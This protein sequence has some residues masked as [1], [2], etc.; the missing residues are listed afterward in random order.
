MSDLFNDEFGNN[1]DDFLNSIFDGSE[2]GNGQGQEMFG[3]SQ[4]PQ[5][6]HLQQTQTFNDGLNPQMFMRQSPPPNQMGQMSQN[7]QMTQLQGQIQPHMPHLGPNKQEQLMKMRQQIM[8]QQQQQQQ[9]Q[10]QPS[11]IQ[12]QPSQIPNHQLQPQVGLQTETLQFQS[13]Q[14]QKPGVRNGSYDNSGFVGS[15]DYQFKPNQNF[16][17]QSQPPQHLQQQPIQQLQQQQIQQQQIQQQLQAQK[18]ANPQPSFK[19]T[20]QQIA[21]LQMEV[22]SRSYLDFVRSRGSRVDV[23]NLTINN[24]RINVFFFYVLSQKLGGQLALMKAI[25]QSGS[26]RA[27]P[28]LV[29]GQKLGVINDNQ[30]QA[31][32]MQLEKEVASFYLQFIHPYEEYSLTPDG[33]KALQQKKILIQKQFI[34]NLQQ[35]QPQQFQTQAPGSLAGH[36]SPMVLQHNSPMA[37]SPQLRASE[38]FQGKA[39]SSSSLGSPVLQSSYPQTKPSRS[40]SGPQSNSPRVKQEGEPTIVKNLLANR[41]PTESYGGVDIKTV[42]SIGGEIDISKPVYLFAPELGTVDIQSLTMLL[43]NNIKPWNGEIISALNTLLV[44]SSEQNTVIDFQQCVE[45]LEALSDT[46]LK[47]LDEIA[48]DEK[49]LDT[50]EVIDYDNLR[51]NYVVDEVFNKYVKPGIK[52]EDIMFNVDSLT[53]E[54]VKEEDDDIDMDDIFSPPQEIDTRTSD[55]DIDDDEYQKEDNDEEVIEKFGFKDYNQILIDFKSENKH[56]FSTLQT[57]SAKDHSLLMVDEL[58]SITM[59]LRNMSFHPHNKTKMSSNDTFKDFLFAVIKMVGMYPEKFLFNRKRLC[60]TK[61]CLFLLYNISQEVE[62][63]SLEEAF[64]SL[65]LITSFGP[66]LNGTESIPIA[67]VDKY[68]YLPYGI[69]ALTKLLVREPHNRSFMKAVLTG[70]LNVTSNRTT[71]KIEDSDKRITR[72][73]ITKYLHTDDIHQGQ[74]LTRTFYLFLCIVPFNTNS[75]EFSKI[76]NLRVSTFTQTFFGAKILVDLISDAESEFKEL[77]TRWLIN[78]RS[79]ILVNLLKISISLNPESAKNK[80]LALV[81]LKCMIMIN[82]L[83]NNTVMVL[84]NGASDDLRREIKL[85]VSVRWLYPDREITLETLMNPVSEPNLCNELLRLWGL[86]KQIEVVV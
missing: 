41:K 50:G 51:T 42:S 59:I 47:V 86:L 14:S 45:L 67:N 2:Q 25:H 71:I 26:N 18:P 1:G 30:N 31:S 11:Q 69:D 60:L 3:V 12:Q 29:I 9:I 16:Q 65:A 84:E 49:E 81:L 17:R 76:V 37:N 72:K 58:I 62:L 52:D 32:K 15:T 35:E 10:Q 43:K 68:S 5:S 7:P 78:N 38:A 70:D 48:Y 56:H 34:L 36:Q 83:V 82:T 23:N 44:T 75:F 46:G 74:L 64:L 40:A 79:E 28:W 22:F 63:R 19:P 8:Q 33:Q 21:Q 85:L 4:H 77:S 66:D 55:D 73:L 6:T 61:D 27:S 53:G 24:K 57:K 39:R 13:A 80:L 54:M 20:P